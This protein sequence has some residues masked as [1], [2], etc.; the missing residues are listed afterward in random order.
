MS[1][2]LISFGFYSAIGQ[3]KPKEE[4]QKEEELLRAIGEQ[5]K[6][7]N[8]QK[9]AQKRASEELEK[10]IQELEKLKDF[11]FDFNYDDYGDNVRIYRKG[12]SMMPE[13]FRVVVPAAPNVPMI[14]YFASGGGEGTSWDM[15]RSVKESSFKKEY[16]FEVEKTA[17][18]VTLSVNGD[19][20]AGEI[21]IRILTP[22]GKTYSDVVIDEFGNLNVRKSFTIS[23]EEN[24]DKVGDWKFI[25]DSSKATGYFRISFQTR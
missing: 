15:S 23:E 8:A 25:V 5:K 11:D 22:N 9:E 3:D 6:A 4:Q 21:R 24:Q 14:H 19:C 13:D 2:L 10:S 20:R 17:K 12:R 7:L 18:S 16:E 1:I